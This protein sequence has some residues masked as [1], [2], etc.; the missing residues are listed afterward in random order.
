MCSR[1]SFSPSSA[2][3][4]PARSQISFSK[5]RALPYFFPLHALPFQ[6]RKFR[7]PGFPHHHDC[8]AQLLDP[9]LSRIHLG[10]DQCELVVQSVFRAT[11]APSLLRTSHRRRTSSSRSNRLWNFCN[12]P[13]APRLLSAA[14]P[15]RSPSPRC[16]QMPERPR[17]FGRLICHK[18]PGRW[19]SD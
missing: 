1:V 10:R 9:G 19:T 7:P 8:L 11:P 17:P 5:P 15:W 2:T 14:A 16:D 3:L 12:R 18:I 6:I 4:S 13:M